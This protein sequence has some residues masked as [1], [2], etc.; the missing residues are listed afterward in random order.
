M[1]IMRFSISRETL[2][3]TLQ[4]VSGI[5]EKRQ[6]MPI[7]ANLLVEAKETGLQLLGSDQEIQI[8]AQIPADL[9]QPCLTTLPAKKLLDICK[10]LPDKADLH[11]DVEETRCVITSG[12]SRFTLATMSANDFPVLGQ[13]EWDFE[14]EITQKDLREILD[15][16]SFAMAQQDV[17]YFLNGLMLEFGEDYLRAVAADGHRLALCEVAAKTGLEDERQIIVPRKAVLELTR[18]LGNTDDVVRMQIGTNH[19]RL[20]LGQTEFTTKLLDGR[21][22]E[23]RRVIPE[24]TKCEFSID[25]NALRYALV[26]VAILCNEKYRGVRAL[27]TSQQVLTIQSQNPEQEEAEE[28]LEI[29]QFVGPDLDTGFNVNYLL[30]AVSVLKGDTISMR[31]A[32]GSSTCLVESKEDPLAKMVVMPM[33]F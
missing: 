7:L 3:P 31:F 25:K 16:T 2:L 32:E 11:V 5:I 29:A 13:I 23:Y 9:S 22:P 28:Q 4:I 21:F 17:R 20:T 12:R 19:L 14:I 33:R 24:H 26:R 27:A 6:T 30:D 8:N 10:N 15:K 18:M 1:D